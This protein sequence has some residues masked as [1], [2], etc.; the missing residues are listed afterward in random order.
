MKERTTYDRMIVHQRDDHRRGARRE[1]LSSVALQHRLAFA[2]SDDDGLNL[3]ATDLALVPRRAPLRLDGREPEPSEQRDWTA[4]RLS[5]ANNKASRG[6][7]L[8]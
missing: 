5:P 8:Y 4:G 6:Q 1:K 7:W 2:F 3:D